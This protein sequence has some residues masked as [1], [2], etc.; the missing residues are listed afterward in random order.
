[1]LMPPPL[2]DVDEALGSASVA[3]SIET[4]KRASLPA[5]LDNIAED[6]ER[7]TPA[8]AL[9]APVED[10]HRNMPVVRGSSSTDGTTA[11][12]EATLHVEEP[13]ST[14]SSREAAEV[15]EVVADQFVGPKARI[16]KM[17]SLS[18]VSVVNASENGGSNK[19][20][21]LKTRASCRQTS[22]VD[23]RHVLGRT[24]INDYRIVKLLGEGSFGTVF[25]AVHE[26][27]S[28]SKETD[29][30]I[31]VISLTAITVKNAEGNLANLGKELWA[32]RKL[33]HPN[34]VTML[35]VIEDETVDSLYALSCPPPCRQC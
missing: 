10:D 13:K 5:A 33:R 32:L 9:T 7:G 8:A 14:D 16:K 26:G 11:E 17:P 6:E 20:Q 18:K 2:D 29:A 12:L 34:C 23:Y 31:K 30:A 27:V 28:A 25:Q 22:N 1:M 15:E 21:Q 35:E 19:Y 24:Y 4:R 3:S